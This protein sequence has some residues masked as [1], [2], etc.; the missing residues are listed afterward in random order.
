M[1]NELINNGF[2][3]TRE[4]DYKKATSP[5]DYDLTFKKRKNQITQKPTNEIRE[6]RTPI[7][8]DCDDFTKIDSC[9]SN[10]I[11]VQSPGK[12]TNESISASRVT[13][14]SDSSCT[15]GICIASTSK[16]NEDIG[17]SWAE[18]GADRGSRMDTQV[19]LSLH[20]GSLRTVTPHEEATYS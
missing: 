2:D 10:E 13:E 12:V 6:T 16:S 19:R 4:G 15:D 20:Q 17:V 1:D 11:T 18:E 14:N 3:Q 9:K 5:L 8:Q 7:K